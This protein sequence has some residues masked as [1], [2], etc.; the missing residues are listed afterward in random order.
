MDGQP[1]A[2]HVVGF[3]AQQVEKLCVKDRHDKVKGVV[4]VSDD[5]EQCRFLVA[6][7]VKLHFVG[8]QKLPQLPYVKGGKPRPAGNED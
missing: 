4:R 6:Q 3:V 5:N 7:C 8:F 2:V 1:P